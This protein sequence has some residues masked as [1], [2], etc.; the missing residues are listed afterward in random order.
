MTQSKKINMGKSH[1]FHLWGWFRGNNFYWFP[2]FI[3]NSV[4][5]LL[6]ATTS[7]GSSSL[8]KM[9]VPKNRSAVWY[10]YIDLLLL[11][12]KFYHWKENCGGFNRF[13]P[14]SSLFH[15]AEANLLISA[16]WADG[17]IPSL[18]IENSNTI[19]RAREAK[20][21][22]GIIRSLCLKLRGDS[23]TFNLW[24]QDPYILVMGKI[25]LY[26]G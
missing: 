10:L 23:P 15:F 21:F 20:F 1:S 12:I 2:S 19:Y 18:G 9:L 4:C 26:L 11:S 24:F 7:L 17:N 22:K 5:P 6:S 3:N 16:P 25:A 8:T 13:C 14:F